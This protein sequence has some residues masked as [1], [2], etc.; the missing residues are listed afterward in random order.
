MIPDH[1]PSPASDLSYVDWLDRIWDARLDRS[2][3]RSVSL[4]V[5]ILLWPT[6]PM[7]SLTGIVESLR[8]AGDY[9]DHSQQRYVRWHILGPPGTRIR[10]SCGIEV[11]TT[12]DYVHP[13]EFDILFVVGGLLKDIDAAPAAH[14][15]Y[16]HAAHRVGRTIAGVCT[17]S[18]ILAQEK[19]L[20]R[21]IA[22][23]HPYH[24]ADF[25]LHFPNHR[26]TTRSDYEGE[27]GI[28][29]IP[30]GISILSFM[31][32]LIRDHFGPDRAAKAVHQLSLTEGTGLGELQRVGLSR[33][34]EATDPRVQKALV[35]LDQRATETPRIGQIA[36]SLG[37][38][39]RHFLRLFKAQVGMSPKSYMIDMKLRAAVWMLRNSARSV[40]AIAYAA[41]FSS[42]A[43]L[44]GHCARR[45]NATPSQIRAGRL[46]L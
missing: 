34:I 36:E 38:T 1:P 32:R 29:T 9:G 12:H 6:F 26:A 4:T 39:E 27:E 33:H 8:H 21:Q 37:L 25:K 16:I 20:D 24:E 41:G 5:G 28:V 3:S 31:T 42:A 17:G 15:R 46:N 13:G 2:D 7:M 18:F 10:A 30:G 23:I 11:G 14:R 43:S 35:M 44:S 40:T 22:C 45:L 19:L